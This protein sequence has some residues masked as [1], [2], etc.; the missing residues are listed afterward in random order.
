MD[1]LKIKWYETVDETVEEIEN[2]CADCGMSWD[3]PSHATWEP[4][5]ME[6]GEPSGEVQCAEDHT[7]YI[8]ENCS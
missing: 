8:C 5:C 4:A 1:F 3:D 7:E 2:E 6:C